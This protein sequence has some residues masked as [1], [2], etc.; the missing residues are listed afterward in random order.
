[1]RVQGEMY[2]G[3]TGCIL[4]VQTT[5]VTILLFHTHLSLPFFSVRIKHKIGKN[6]NSVQQQREHHH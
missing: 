3:R 5:L 2:G 1:M 4:R 6:I